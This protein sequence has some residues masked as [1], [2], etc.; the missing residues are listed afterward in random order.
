MGVRNC[1]PTVYESMK[2]NKQVAASIVRHQQGEWNLRTRTIYLRCNRCYPDDQAL[3]Y[4]QSARLK[5]THMLNSCSLF[6]LTNFVIFVATNQLVTIYNNAI[7]NALDYSC[8]FNTY[9]YNMII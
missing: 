8:Y 6:S 4:V 7:T 1:I 2:W 3:E 5:S 9:A